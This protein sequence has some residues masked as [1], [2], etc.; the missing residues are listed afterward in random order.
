MKAGEGKVDG[1]I[2]LL[3]LAEDQR[4]GALRAAAIFA[5]VALLRLISS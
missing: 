5:L 3:M 1:R 2:A 4:G